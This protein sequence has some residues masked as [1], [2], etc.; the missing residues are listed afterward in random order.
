M[1]TSSCAT[2]AEQLNKYKWHK[3]LNTKILACMEVFTL[4]IFH[5][6]IASGITGR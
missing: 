4:D 3:M 5:F 1:G 2:A 6:G